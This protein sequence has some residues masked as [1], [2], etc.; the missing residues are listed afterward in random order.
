MRD[1]AVA[2]HAE[3][4]LAPDGLSARP[5]IARNPWPRPT[6]PMTMPNS[7]RASRETG[8]KSF[9]GIEARLGLHHRQQI[10]G[11]TGGH[12]DGGAVGIGALDRLDP[13]QPVAAGAVLDDDVRSSSWPMRCA[14]TRHSVSPPPPAAN[15][16]MILVNDAACARAAFVLANSGHARD[17]VMKSRR[18]IPRPSC[19]NLAHYSRTARPTEWSISSRC[20][21]ASQPTRRKSASAPLPNR[22][23]GAYWLPLTTSPA[24]PT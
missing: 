14:S 15:G 13:D 20:S 11:R 23:S 10:H 21:L 3:G 7:K 12:E 16:K 19:S 8:T 18:S 6:G 22:R 1:G 4:R 24:D 17:A 9:V 5:R 2:R